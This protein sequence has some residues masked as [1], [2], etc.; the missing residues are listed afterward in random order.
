MTII[1]FFLAEFNRL[2][3]HILYG[4]QVIPQWHPLF[5]KRCWRCGWYRRKLIFYDQRVLLIVVYRFYCPETKT[6][7][8]LLPFFIDRYERHIN[9]VIE[10]VLIR[11]FLEGASIETLA[12]EPAPSPWTIKRWLKK[13]Q[14]RFILIRQSVEEFLITNVPEYHPTAAWE[15]S[16]PHR[17]ND[18]LH[19]ANRLAIPMNHLV[20][21]GS[22]SY[23]Q[24]V[25]AVQNPTF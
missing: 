23:L 7:Y 9:T 1:T 24:Y 25:T 12:E 8:S 4:P 3:T 21:Y 18:L 14:D 10:D 6:T 5:G 19:K 16:F 20:L 15:N 22:L 17:L 11:Y 2:Q 13:F